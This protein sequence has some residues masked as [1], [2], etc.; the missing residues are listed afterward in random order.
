MESMASIDELS[1]RFDAEFAEARRRVEQLQQRAAREAESVSDRYEKFE[2]LRHRITDEIVLPRIEAMVEHFDS[3]QQDAHRHRFGADVVLS[4][5]RTTACPANVELTL[6]LSRDERIEQVVLAYDLKI[7]P[8]FTKF[9][10]HAEFQFALDEFDESKLTTW[11]EEQL[12]TF[13][14]TYL[15]LQFVDQ[16]QQDNLVSD[17]VANI[18]FPKSFAKATCEHDKHTYYFLSD[19]S[20]AEFEKDPALFIASSS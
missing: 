1:K 18:R 8:V 14:Q 16:Y 9:E 4:F 19:A 12:V 20:K 13:V 6:S 11:L 2:Q 3:V 7:L 17:P 10:P 15:S 5:G